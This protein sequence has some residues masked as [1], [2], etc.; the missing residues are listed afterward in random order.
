MKLY[1]YTEEELDKD[2]PSPLNL[3]EVTIMS[4]P[5]ELRKIA[6]FLIDKANDIEQA[7]KGF[8]HEHLCDVDPSFESEPHI[9]VWND[10]AL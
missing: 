6:K 3:T 9:I 5:S 4:N 10:A 7:E 1:G 8:E 2:E